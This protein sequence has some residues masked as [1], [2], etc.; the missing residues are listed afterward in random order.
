[1]VNYVAYAQERLDKL[2]KELT[3][4]G[5]RPI[6]F[7]GSGLSQR[8]FGAPNWINIIKQ[9]FDNIHAKYPFEYYMQ[10][11]NQDLIKIADRLVNLYVTR[12]WKQDLRKRA[13]KELY[14]S[15]NSK[16]IFLKYQIAQLIKNVS[17][18][19]I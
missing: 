3:A 5:R 15:H 16:D 9:L 18:L 10:E 19:L 11:N 13:P 1:M 17:Q 12:Y 2:K 6:L 7:V 4:S 14:D 8:Y